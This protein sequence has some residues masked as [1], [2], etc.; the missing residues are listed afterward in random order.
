MH[1]R[2]TRLTRLGGVRC[3]LISNPDART[4]GWRSIRPAV[5]ASTPTR[6]VMC[7]VNASTSRQWA[8][9]SNSFE[10]ASASPAARAASKADS[11]CDTTAAISASR[12]SAAV[13][14]VSFMGGD[15]RGRRVGTD[16]SAL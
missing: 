15:L 10:V 1:S 16:L 11:H 2:P 6:G 13:V 3:G 12:T 8:S 7:Q 9:R 4:D 14:S 5:I